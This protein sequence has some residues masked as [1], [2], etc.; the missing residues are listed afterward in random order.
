MK[1]Y[2]LI[3]IVLFLAA[4][5]QGGGSSSSAKPAGSDNS[6][7]SVSDSFWS[8]KNI[9]CTGS[10]VDGRITAT[11]GIHFEGQKMTSVVELDSSPWDKPNHEYF[12]TL[13][14]CQVGTAEQAQQLHL[15]AVSFVN[16]MLKAPGAGY[17]ANVVFLR[18]AVD[19]VT[20]MLS[21]EGLEG[22]GINGNCKDQTP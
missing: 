5:S 4:C 17:T 9:S 13:T 22:N 14:N 19:D 3:S 7:N 1:K 20:F 2:S 10:Y 12:Y 21:A 8:A 16:C 6:E 15:D 11:T 18:N